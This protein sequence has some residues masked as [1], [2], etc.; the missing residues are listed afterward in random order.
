MSLSLVLKIY[1]LSLYGRLMKQIINLILQV[2]LQRLRKEYF[3]IPKRD[4][5]FRSS[6]IAG[7]TKRKLPQ[8]WYLRYPAFF[9]RYSCISS[10]SAFFP[11]TSQ[12]TFTA[13]MSGT[14]S[15]YQSTC[16]LSDRITKLVY[17]TT[18][19]HLVFLPRLSCLISVRC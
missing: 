10:S 3:Q 17:T 12:N 16:S 2:Q 6:F 11:D 18:R 4:K 19:V 9:V 15:A 1:S 14:T 13:D 5:R 8:Q 7:D